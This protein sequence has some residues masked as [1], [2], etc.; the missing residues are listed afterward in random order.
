MVE[1]E[2]KPSSD[3]SI[4]SVDL[5][6]HYKVYCREDGY[7]AV[8]KKNFRKRLEAL[9]YHIERKNT[10]MVIYAEH[11]SPLSAKNSVKENGSAESAESDVDKTSFSE[12]LGNTK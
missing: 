8:G 11:V 1:S 3:K 12:A 2:F 9:G 4:P 6:K 7:L 10:G 5:Y